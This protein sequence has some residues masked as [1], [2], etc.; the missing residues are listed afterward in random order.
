MTAVA[1]TPDR[2]AP[3]ARSDPAPG[4]GTAGPHAVA[5]GLR[6]P[7]GRAHHLPPARRHPAVQSV[8]PAVG[9]AAARGRPG[10]STSTATS[11]RATGRCRWA[12]PSTSSLHRARH[13][14]TVA[15]H[16][17]PRFGTVWADAGPGPGLLRPELGPRGRRA[18]DRRRV[19][20]AG[21]RPRERRTERWPPWA[22]PTWPCWPTTACS[23]P[24]A[25]SGRPT[26]GRWPSSTGAGGPGRSRRWEAVGELP[27]PARSFFGVLRRRG[28]HRVLR[29]H[30]PA[31]AAPRP[32]PA[33]RPPAGVGKAILLRLRAGTY[34]NVAFSD[35]QKLL[36]ARYDLKVEEDR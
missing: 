2:S 16:S 25:A 32:H 10:A 5:G 7:P 14:V 30:G 12:S 23:S 13:D 35:A 17:H 34:T 15:V 36:A 11:W 24:P 9:G 28:L 8:A 1:V 33:R 29:G 26:S 31:R 18:G 3:A 21:Q 4:A 20:R 6:R 27:E 19:R 22:R